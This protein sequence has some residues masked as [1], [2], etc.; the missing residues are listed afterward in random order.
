[1]GCL[2]L[3]YR[4]KEEGQI[5]LNLGEKTGIPEKCNDYY[6]FGL[7]FNSYQRESSTK[8]NYLYN[9]KELQDELDL[10]WMD[11]GARMYMPE[12]GRFNRIDRFSEKYLNLTPYQ[13]AV[14]NPLLFVD[15]NGDSVKTYFFD[16]NGNQL[17]TV[18]DAVQQMFNSEYGISVGYNSETGMMYY[19]G[20][21]E[22]ENTV[23]ESAKEIVVSALSDNVGGKKAVRKY[24]EIVF[25]DGNF[26]TMQPPLSVSEGRANRRTSWINLSHFDKDGSSKMQNYSKFD[27]AGFS[28]RAYNLGRV[29]EHEWIGHTLGNKSDP[30]NRFKAG[31]TVSIVNKFRR[32][33]GL[34]ERLNYGKPIYFS[35][36]NSRSSLKDLRNK[37]KKGEVVPVIY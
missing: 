14:N 17:T 13:Y 32:E 7:T 10:G 18:P 20:E 37:A 3:T 1:M 35:H 6:P 29:F 12:I 30:S 28:R 21:V 8:N 2:R 4:E 11:Y 25:G 5:F 23:S 9:G 16:K 34:P 24:G 22:T 33:M 19:S 15:V 31:P 27:A 26:G 36:D